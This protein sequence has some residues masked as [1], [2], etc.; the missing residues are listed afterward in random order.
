MF[1]R[2]KKILENYTESEIKEDS[3][4][5]ADLGLSSLDIVSIVADFEDEFNIKIE[6]KD[7]YNFLTVDDILK[8]L[9]EK[10]R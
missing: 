6:D 3:S 4:L 10:C 2:V 7:I 5:V 8:Y 1:D 9:E